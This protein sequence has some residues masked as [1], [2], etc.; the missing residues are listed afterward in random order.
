MLNIQ[1]LPAT[2]PLKFDKGMQRTISNDAFIYI[3]EK[4]FDQSGMIDWS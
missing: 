1:A 2:L 3:N 4:S